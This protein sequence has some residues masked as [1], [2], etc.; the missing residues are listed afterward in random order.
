MLYRRLF[1]AWLF[2]ILVIGG[3]VYAQE[4]T[5]EATAEA[6]AAVTAAP[7]TTAQPEAT[8]EAGAATT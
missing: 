1:V 6:T 5:A 2:T 4:S 3:S 7:E 8:A